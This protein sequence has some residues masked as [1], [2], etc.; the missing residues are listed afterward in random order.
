[1]CLAKTINDDVFITYVRKE[2]KLRSI[3]L[4]RE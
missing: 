1:V 4:V 2:E 3:G